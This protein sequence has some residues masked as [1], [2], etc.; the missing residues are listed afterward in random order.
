MPVL[1]LLGASLIVVLI[2]WFFLPGLPLRSVLLLMAIVL[3]VVFLFYTFFIQLVDLLAQFRRLLFGPSPFPE[4]RM[5]NEEVIALAAAAF[6]KAGINDVLLW[7][8]V[9]SIDGRL[10]WIVGTAT[11]GS[12]YTVSIEDATGVVGPVKHWGVR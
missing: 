9:R 7:P 2:L 3:L 11:I 12:G 4:T 6:G 10:T 8:T 1:Y 5:T